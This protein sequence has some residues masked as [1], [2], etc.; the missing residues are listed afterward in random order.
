MTQWFLKKKTPTRPTLILTTCYVRK[1]NVKSITSFFFKMCLLTCNIYV[2]YPLMGS[3]LFDN[4][5][6]WVAIF[7]TRIWCVR[8][9]ERCKNK[10]WLLWG[11]RGPK[12]PLESQELLIKK[13]TRKSKSWIKAK[14]VVWRHYCSGKGIHL[15][16]IISGQGEKLETKLGLQGEMEKWRN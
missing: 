15:L 6:R 1:N 9:K 3:R 7:K 10:P 11:K 4:V 14:I 8:G 12:W 16:I 2:I 13:I 5:F